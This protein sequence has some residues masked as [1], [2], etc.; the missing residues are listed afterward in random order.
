MTIKKFLADNRFT[1]DFYTGLRDIKHK[2]IQAVDE[3]RDFAY[4]GIFDDR[5]RGHSKLC[6]VLAGYK[7]YLYVA[8]MERIKTYIDDD[9]DVCIVTSGKYSSDID[10]MCQQEGW[11]YLSTK[12]NNVALV[13][14]VAI[15][16]HPKAEWIYKLDEDI[17]ITDGYFS[18][19]M[20]AYEH[21]EDG[22]FNPGV[23]A[24]LI[25]VNGYGH[26]RILQ[27]IGVVDDYTN[28]FEK[29]K[30]AAGI[31]RKIEDDP[32]A[33]K[34][35]W[36]EGGVVPGIDDLND[37][38]KNDPTEERPCP[39]RF[40]IGAILFKRSLWEDMNHY[41]VKKGSGIGVD[42]EQICQYCSVN[43]RP[44]M[45]SENIVVGHLS[46]GRQNGAMK[47]YFLSNPE[48]FAIPQKHLNKKA[49]NES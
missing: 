47:K 16:L 6:I 36:G 45:V 23:L 1:K 35:M 22:E 27:K 30:Y 39:I 10:K 7:S 37:L 44:L 38:F 19:M 29:P 3:H 13:Q 46:F 18:N 4:R 2:T 32:D 31:D 26:M 40:S 49:E 28:R 15:K 21:A 48:V 20:K 41:T 5:Q 24:P 33:A 12:Q 17:F 34:F 25:P 43:S 42:E 11:S 8:T 14:N 9:I